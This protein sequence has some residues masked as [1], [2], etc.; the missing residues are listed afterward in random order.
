MNFFRRATEKHLS[1][2][3]EAGPQNLCLA[4]CST[5]KKPAQTPFKYA[6]TALEVFDDWTEKEDCGKVLQDWVSQNQ[7]KG[8]PCNVALGAGEYQLLL[9]DAPDVPLRELRDAIRWKVKDLSS[10]PLE[11]A[12]VDAFLLP[13]DGSR[14]AR[15]MAYVVVS[16]L[17]KITRII[18]LMQQAELTLNSIDISELALRNLSLLKP[19]ATAENSGVGV[20][21]VFSGRASVNIY[22]EGN[23]Y[24]SRQFNLDDSSGLADEITADNFLLEVQ[25]SLDYY[26]RQMAQ[27]PPA[28]LYICGDHICESDINAHISRGL[29][30]P[31][32]YL[33]LE[34]LFYMVDDAFDEGGLQRCCVAL[35]AALRNHVG[36]P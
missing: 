20:V 31:A 18:N 17:N 9:T 6:V 22:R 7:L 24:L 15:P 5:Q 14:S 19:E 34:K 30:V 26:E 11:Q 10:I 13:A 33:E 3:L 16:E 1:L 12:A 4:L 27:T 21:Q 28:L 32:K 2:G 36:S 8:M 29:S 25:R 35:G 23:L